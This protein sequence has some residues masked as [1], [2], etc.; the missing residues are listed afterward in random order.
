MA[1]TKQE[2][3]EGLT[4]AE[5][6][7][8]ADREGVDLS[9]L[10][11]KQEIADKVATSVTKDA[12]TAD[13]T[14]TE[15]SETKAGGAFAASEPTYQDGI[16]E[17][18]AKQPFDTGNQGQGTTEWSASVTGGNAN[19]EPIGEGDAPPSW[20]DEP[21]V[22]SHPLGP[23]NPDPQDAAALAVKAPR[24]ELGQV[25]NDPESL[26]KAGLSPA[27]LE[28]PSSAFGPPI[29]VKQNPETPSPHQVEGALAT[30][31]GPPETT[32][33]VTDGDGNEIPHRL[34]TDDQALIASRAAASL[35]THPAHTTEGHWS[36]PALRDMT[37]GEREADAEAYAKRFGL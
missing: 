19:A 30:V 5:L 34:G 24:N 37:A 15:D 18:A 33:T 32:V 17:T 26:Q 7:A 25:S 14:S 12:L 13:T 8:V 22:E 20:G 36:N 21:L 6:R 4:V 1:D 9:G 2:I 27:D 23:P 35:S 16:D 10:T 29:I 3:A 11:A 28:L 31:P